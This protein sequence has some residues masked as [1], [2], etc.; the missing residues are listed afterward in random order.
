MGP[1]FHST[2]A[3][4]TTDEKPSLS[5][6]LSSTSPTSRRSACAYDDP[7]E[8]GVP[9]AHHLRTTPRGAGGEAAPDGPARPEPARPDAGGA[10]LL[11][12]DPGRR[13]HRPRRPDRPGLRR[14]RAGDPAYPGPPG[15]GG[16][17]PTPGG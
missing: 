6:S 16:Q 4:A 3:P 2:G 15:P 8:Q 12:H 10:G 1:R 14:G 9:S 13:G 5:V 17:G 7:N 11:R